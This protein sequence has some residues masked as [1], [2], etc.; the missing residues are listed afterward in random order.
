MLSWK[1]IINGSIGTG[2]FVGAIFGVREAISQKKVYLVNTSSRLSLAGGEEFEH[3]L[4]YDGPGP[5]DAS[6][7]VANG[8]FAP[9]KIYPI[10]S[11]CYMFDGASYYDVPVVEACA[12]IDGPGGIKC[13]TVPVDAGRAS[14]TIKGK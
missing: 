4:T 12:P 13:R 5:C 7:T 9:R 3:T 8:C 1:N 11:S 6:S 2:V 10:T 14:C